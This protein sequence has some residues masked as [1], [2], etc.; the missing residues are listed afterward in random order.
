MLQKTSTQRAVAAMQLA[1]SKGSSPHMDADVAAES[2]ALQSRCEV[3]IQSQKMLQASLRLP[4]V[5]MQSDSTKQPQQLQGSSQ[6]PRGMDSTLIN[7]LLSLRNLCSMPFLREGHVNMPRGSGVMPCQ[8]GD[9]V[10]PAEECT[11]GSIS[12][13][14]AASADAVAEGGSKEDVGHITALI[15]NPAPTE[16][17]NKADVSPISHNDVSG[18]QDT[19]TSVDVDS[20]GNDRYGSEFLS[21]T[22]QSL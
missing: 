11:H 7:C 18:L 4:A 2:A 8:S 16:K 5:G 20:L 9:A 12:S 21:H 14:H 15:A 6:R 17:L 10:I 22:L 1:A 3:W 13:P 19:C